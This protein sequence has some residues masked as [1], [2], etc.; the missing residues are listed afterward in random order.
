MD[1]LY[2]SERDSRK[3][4]WD[5]LVRI[6]AESRRRPRRE[7]TPETLRPPLSIIEVVRDGESDFSELLELSYPYA[8]V[9]VF[10]PLTHM[11]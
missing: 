7:T 6:D 4:V 10:I 5:G 2:T 1:P 8:I 11:P 9:Y 3:R